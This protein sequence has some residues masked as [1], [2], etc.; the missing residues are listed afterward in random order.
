MKDCAIA[1]DTWFLRKKE[2]GRKEKTEKKRNPV[3]LLNRPDCVPPC[4]FLPRL[5]FPRSFPFEGREQWEGSVGL[6]WRPDRIA[7]DMFRSQ[8]AGGP[9]SDGK[10]TDRMHTGSKS[11]RLRGGPRKM[12]SR[13]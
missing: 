9:T 1:I 13:R 12:R 6:R 8:S 5:A 10:G 2:R 4:R 7:I 11:C 3:R